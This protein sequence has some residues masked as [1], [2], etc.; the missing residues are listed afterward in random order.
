MTDNLEKIGGK[1]LTELDDDEWKMIL[2]IIKEKLSLEKQNE[3]GLYIMF[4]DTMKEAW[5]KAIK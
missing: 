2:T 1:I 5:K 3:F 4:G